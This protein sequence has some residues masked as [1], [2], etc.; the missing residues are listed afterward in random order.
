MGGEEPTDGSPHVLVAGADAA[1]TDAGVP[2]SSNALG[3][4]YE[5]DAETWLGEFRADCERTAVVSV[6]EHSRAAAAATPDAGV[7][8]PDNLDA[9]AT[10]AVETV[11]EVTDVASV[12]VLVNDYLSAWDDETTVYVDDFSVLLDPAP[13]ETAFRFAHALTSCTAANDA[14]VVA[15]FDTTDQPPHVPATFA[16]LFGD[17]REP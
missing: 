13:A 8:P 7:D 9:A 4:T 12:G 5:T 15:G 10:S 2:P 17:V 1:A 16:E 11:P 6:G 3:I 14:R